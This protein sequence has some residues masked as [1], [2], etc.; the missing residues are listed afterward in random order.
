MCLVF[1]VYVEP[2]VTEY[3]RTY[4]RPAEPTLLIA[5]LESSLRRRPDYRDLPLPWVRFSPAW[6]SAAVRKPYGW[7]VHLR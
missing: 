7:I 6:L 1:S 5:D 2:H 4:G 3:F